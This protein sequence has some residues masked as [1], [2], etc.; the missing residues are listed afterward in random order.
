[1]A[2]LPN[3]CGTFLNDTDSE[4]YDSDIPPVSVST[5]LL[6]SEI[7]WKQLNVISIDVKEAVSGTSPLCQ[8]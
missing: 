4:I 6:I 7:I 1:M 2:S 5:Q 3:E 8:V